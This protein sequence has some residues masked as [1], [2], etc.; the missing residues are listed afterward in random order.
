MTAAQDVRPPSPAEAPDH[1]TL[2]VYTVP[3]EP[4]RLRASVWRDLKR[5]GAVYLRDGVCALPDT[6][7]RPDARNA[8]ADLAAKV[9]ALGGQATVVTGGRLPRERAGEL[10]AELR[11]VRAVEYADLRLEAE[12]LLASIHRE[13]GHR[14]LGG[15]G[16]AALRADVAKL[17]GWLA[18]IVARDYLSGAPGTLETGGAAAGASAAVERCAAAADGLAGAPV[19]GLGSRRR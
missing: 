6:P 19:V 2:L 8:L 15:R 13:Q 5:A 17:R 7:E 3:S 4:S 16:W 9:R 11:A 14:E 12:R 18:Q 1:W 10:A